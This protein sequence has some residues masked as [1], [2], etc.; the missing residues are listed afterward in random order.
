VSPCNPSFSAGACEIEAERDAKNASI[1]L[2]VGER[3]VRSDSVTAAKSVPI[4]ED[5]DVESESTIP[6]IALP[7]EGVS[8][9]EADNCAKKASEAARTAP[10]DE[11]TA[12]LNPERSCPS[13]EL[14]PMEA[15]RFCTN[16]IIVAN[17]GARLNE[18]P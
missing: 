9:K 16:A 6:A 2:S 3:L 18:A 10:S 11:E 17:A 7:E 8:D 1:L 4:D 5:S 14:R 15:E 12:S 13:P